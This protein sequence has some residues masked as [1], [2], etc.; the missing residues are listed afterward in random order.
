MISSVRGH[1]Q[2]NLNKFMDDSVKK[3]N[4]PTGDP[5]GRLN[6]KKIMI[7]GCG[8]AGKSTLA[9]ELGAQMN[10]DVYHLDQLF[11]E[12]QLGGCSER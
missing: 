4:N 11:L 1:N 7:I 8:G 9:R 10:L 6:M 12:T 5:L 2:G 3:Y